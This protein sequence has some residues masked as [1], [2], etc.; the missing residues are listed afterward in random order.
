MDEKLFNCSSCTRFKKRLV[1][2]SILRSLVWKYHNFEN[3]IFELFCEVFVSI[4]I[5]LRQMFPKCSLHVR[6]MLLVSNACKKPGKNVTKTFQL[7]LFDNSKHA[8][9]ENLQ[10]WPLL[11]N[12]VRSP[13]PVCSPIC[14]WFIGM[15]LICILSGKNYSP[16]LAFWWCNIKKCWFFG[17]LKM[18]I[19]GFF[20]TC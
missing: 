9:C 15:A 6:W 4:I 20:H 14:I 2:I 3:S 1:I 10:K 8:V 11:H 7:K 5:I 17:P 19:F 18:W 12:L 16:K 13:M